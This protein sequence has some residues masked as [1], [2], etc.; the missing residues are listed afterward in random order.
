M[1]LWQ[2]S[3]RTLGAE[4]VCSIA[5]VVLKARPGTA[6]DDVNN[7]M[8]AAST[9]MTDAIM[10]STEVW[11]DA[12]WSY[13]CVALCYGNREGSRSVGYAKNFTVVVSSTERA[14][15][16]GTEVPVALQG[17][18]LRCL[19]KDKGKQT[20]HEQ[21]L[22]TSYRLSG[23]SMYVENGHPDFALRYTLEMSNLEGFHSLRHPVAG[24]GDLA[25]APTT[26]VIQPGHGQVVAILS[27]NCA[28]RYA[29]ASRSQMQQVDPRR[30]GGRGA[31]DPPIPRS[32]G[33]VVQ[34]VNYNGNNV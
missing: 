2:R 23:G 4:D 19:F 28:G 1:T 13:V 29:W 22:T 16:Q 25:A 11:L 6:L 15:A 12:G 24:P 20:H 7:W 10:T 30:G 32:L 21:M 9:D 5:I 31:H 18:A 33:P 27:R 34:A 8:H 26:D 14:E 17:V 3:G